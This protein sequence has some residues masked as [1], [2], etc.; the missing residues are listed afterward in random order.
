MWGRDEG[1]GS[2]FDLLLSGW[3]DAGWYFFYR[4]AGECYVVRRDVLEQRRY[5]RRRLCTTRMSLCNIPEVLVVRLTNVV[6]AG[7]GCFLISLFSLA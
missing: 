2:F 3:G 7:T 1:E 4:W 5:R 6:C